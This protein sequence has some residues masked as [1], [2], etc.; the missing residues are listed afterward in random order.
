MK[1]NWLSILVFVVI[2]MF[3]GHCFAVGNSSAKSL[4]VA[5]IPW[6]VDDIGNLIDLSSGFK[7][8]L[9][10]FLQDDLILQNHFIPSRNHFD[11]NE[12]EK[13]AFLFS[14]P[15]PN[16][17]DDFDADILIMGI[18]HN[19]DFLEIS[20][21]GVES[22]RK[23]SLNLD[24]KRI[25]KEN[26]RDIISKAIIRVL[27]FG[28][29]LTPIYCDEVIDPRASVV[30]YEVLTLEGENIVIKLDYDGE[31]QF[32]QNFQISLGTLKHD[33]EY[34]Y[35]LMDAEGRKVFLYVNV[36]GDKV[37]IYKVTG[38][39]ASDNL[40]ASNEFNFVSK[41]KYVISI[42]TKKT[43]EGPAVTRIFPKLNPYL[44]YEIREG[45]KGVA[46]QR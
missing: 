14:A 15:L 13:I 11:C 17:S 43:N 9:I 10:K 39:V 40:K 31:H 34:K 22:A 5:I 38:E 1:K 36:K 18:M 19:N 35:S 42:I 24:V 41:K 2:L 32:I 30:A 25:N 7:E 27:K 29:L 6:F 20:A 16:L 3:A 28:T 8:D 23:V 26:I 21:F 33:G 46:P 45:D 44:P 4:R 37:T 12:S